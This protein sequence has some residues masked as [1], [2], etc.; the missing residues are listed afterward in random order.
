WGLQQLLG[1]LALFSLDRF[2][3]QL[4]TVVLIGGIA[5]LV[6]V[7]GILLLRVEEIGLVKDAVLAK[8]GRRP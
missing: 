8:L 6:Y 2:T 4:L 5:A 7:G 3:G 1:T